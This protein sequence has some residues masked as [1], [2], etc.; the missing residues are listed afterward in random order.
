MANPEWE[1]YLEYTCVRCEK[2]IFGARVTLHYID[3]R[4]EEFHPPCME[5][6]E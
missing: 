4:E 1:N 2:Q 6:I 3:G 5:K